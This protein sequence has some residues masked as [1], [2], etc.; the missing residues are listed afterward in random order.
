MD[1]GNLNEET[2]EIR[3]AFISLDL[4]VSLYTTAR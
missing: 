1:G 4:N 2:G 3:I